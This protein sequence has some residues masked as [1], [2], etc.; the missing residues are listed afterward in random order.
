MS[1]KSDDILLIGCDGNMGR[2]YSAILKYL[3]Y[4]FTG[5][6]LPGSSVGARDLIKKAKNIIIATPTRTHLPYLGLVESVCRANPIRRA[7]LCEK[8]VVASAEELRILK[9]LNERNF[10]DLYVVNQ[11]QYLPKIRELHGGYHG[12]LTHYNYYNTGKDGLH[13]DCFQLY[14][15]A[16]R[17]VEVG[18]NSPLWSCAINGV[19]CFLSDM[20]LAYIEMLSDFLTDRKNSW[21]FD[22]IEKTTKRILDVLCE[23]Y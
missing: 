1:L 12:M 6:D 11:Y 19:S 7:V 5:I 13:W 20:D 9:E 2:R 18:N 8:P 15:L 23:P 10:F 21:G 22:V 17:D 4:E 16:N 14:A 3:N